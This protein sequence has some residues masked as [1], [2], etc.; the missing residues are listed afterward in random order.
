MCDPSL[1]PEIQRLIFVT[2]IFP[3]IAKWDLPNVTIYDKGERIKIGRKMCD[4][5]IN[6]NAEKAV[7]S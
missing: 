2:E 3:R 1:F 6:T 5:F 4:T 7:S